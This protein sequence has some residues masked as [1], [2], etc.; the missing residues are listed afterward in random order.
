[1]PGV[2][3]VSNTNSYR[4]P[5]GETEAEFTQFLLDELRAQ[6]EQETPD[7]VAAVFIEPVQNSGGTF[8]PPE[9]YC[10]GVREICDE[11]GILLVA[12][13]VICGFGRLGYWFGA[14]ALRTSAP[15]SSRS[16]R[17]SGRRTSRSVACS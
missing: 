14:R 3:H 7:T 11:Y 12:D 13:E 1:M 5:Q 17:A 9:G 10:R 4:R 2:R 6:I 8:T 15:T 16:P